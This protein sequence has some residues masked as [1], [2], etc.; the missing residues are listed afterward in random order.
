[1][2]DEV[3]YNG[4]RVPAG[5]EAPRVAEGG[6]KGMAVSHITPWAQYPKYPYD[7]IDTRE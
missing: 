7:R 5:S 4:L 6:V 2:C 3:F 1:M